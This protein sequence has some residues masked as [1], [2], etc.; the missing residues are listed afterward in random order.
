[1]SDLPSG[2]KDFLGDA[3]APSPRTDAAQ[4][5]DEQWQ[6]E[7]APNQYHVLRQAGTERAGSSPLNEEHRAGVF[8]C[9][10]CNAPL[11]SSAMKYDSGSGWPSFYTAIEGAFETSTDFKA[12]LPRTEYHCANCGG[13]H[14]HIF[15][16]GPAPTGLRYCNNGTALRFI[17]KTEQ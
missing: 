2:L 5:S 3:K 13:H 17:A 10:G 15:K 14:G 9:A 7:L 6:A 4:R 8:V 11:F 1:M 12:L 16:D